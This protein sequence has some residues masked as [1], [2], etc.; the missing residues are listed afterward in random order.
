MGCI[1]SRSTQ[2]SQIK[3]TASHR[4]SSDTKNKHS[5]LGAFPFPQ[6]IISVW[7][8][9]V[10]EQVCKAFLFADASEE[11]ARQKSK[12]PRVARSFHRVYLGFCLV[13]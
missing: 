12:P 2:T 5:C 3:Q 9:L 8:A 4:I 11:T 6:Q 10:R 13:F 1:Q 7:A